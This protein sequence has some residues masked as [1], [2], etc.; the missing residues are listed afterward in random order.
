MSGGKRILII[1]EMVL[2]GML[3]FGC[4]GRTYIIGKNPKLE[5]ITSI[6]F[7]YGGGM[8][9]E[10]NWSYTVRTSSSGSCSITYRFWDDEISDMN[11]TVTEITAEQYR[12]IVATLD[13]L[14]Y[15]RNKKPDGGIMD[16]GG[17][18]SNINWKKSPGGDYHIEG[19]D[20]FLSPALRLINEISDADG[21]EA[22]SAPES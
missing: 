20:G 13:G 3:L 19:K 16:A 18:F 10:S 8:S 17:S 1:V 15:V 5:D 11:E 22:D 6:Y 12:E 4:G 9:R 2:L 21:A 14:R 7:G